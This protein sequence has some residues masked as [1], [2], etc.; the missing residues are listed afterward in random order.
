M[1]KQPNKIFPFYN[2]D[3]LENLK[4]NYRM[5]FLK[6]FIFPELF[7]PDQQNYLQEYLMLHSNNIILYL[8]DNIEEI[9]GSIE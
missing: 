7:K 4:I 6:D 9:F 1:N 8:A 2:Q 3:I 5:L